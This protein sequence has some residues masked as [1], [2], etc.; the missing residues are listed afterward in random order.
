[1]TAPDICQICG[2]AMRQDVALCARCAS[3]V[4]ANVARGAA[5]LGPGFWISASIGLCT[6]LIAVAV[7]RS[8]NAGVATIDGG[9]A[10]IACALVLQ[11]ASWFLGRWLISRGLRGFAWF[12]LA[13]PLLVPWVLILAATAVASRFGA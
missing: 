6:S 11:I 10:V 1:M 4:N 12:V 8:G 2:T 9:A 3:G 7:F 5:G 13:A